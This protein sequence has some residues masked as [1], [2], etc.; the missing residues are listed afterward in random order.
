VSWL[1]GR[2]ISGILHRSS[3]SHAAT[4]PQGWGTRP[5]VS[6]ALTTLGAMVNRHHASAAFAAATLLLAGCSDSASGGAAPSTSS[7]SASTTATSSTT[8]AAPPTS[9]AHPPTA[10]STSTAVGD[11]NVPLAARAHTKAGA[12]AFVRNYVQLINDS[13]IKPVSRPLRNLSLAPCKTCSNFD[14]SFS[15]LNR[16]SHRL[17]GPVFTVLGTKTKFNSDKQPEVAVQLRQHA[18]SVLGEKGE[19][20]SFARGYK[21][22]MEFDL[23]WS[24]DR[25]RVYKI[26]TLT[27]IP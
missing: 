16:Q 19:V 21:L 24:R 20:I 3:P 15:T 11:T 6:G 17:S 10:S 4:R 23:Q 13:G 2:P 18:V 14:A 22:A 26:Y 8:P 7:T 27:P 12:E 25:W 1:Q 9:S 5:G